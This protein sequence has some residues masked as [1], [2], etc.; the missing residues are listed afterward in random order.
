MNEIKYNNNDELSV[1]DVW[2]FLKRQYK[3]IILIFI[4]CFT[5]VCAYIFT[6]PT[7]YESSADIVV[8][9]KFFFAIANASANPNAIE[10]LEQIKYL[11]SSNAT[12]TP[13]KNT[14]VVRVIAKNTSKE[15]SL[16]AVEK[17]IEEI[18]KNH[19]E[20]LQSKK[21]EAV[22]LLKLT[23]N[24][25][26]ESTTEL[27]D[28]ISASS[29]TKQVSQITTATLTYSGMLNKGVGLG[30]IGSILFALILALMID[31]TFKFRKS[32]KT[33]IPPIS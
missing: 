19:K 22:Q 1:L 8:G 28:K 24:G 2:N 10:P 13:I 5:L 4:V 12:I 33:R 9:T 15:A 17:T 32:I 14:S 23:N 7:I 25:N 3:N 6:R 11:Y 20:Y 31:Y 29:N 18:V 27:I 26:K 21:D 30:L 16:K